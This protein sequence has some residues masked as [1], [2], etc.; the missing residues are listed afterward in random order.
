MCLDFYGN[1]LL[2]SLERNARDTSTKMSKTYNDVDG[3]GND[4]DKDQ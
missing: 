3:N 1:G 2:S 4:G